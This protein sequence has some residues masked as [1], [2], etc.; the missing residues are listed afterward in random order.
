M[1][2]RFSIGYLALALLVICFARDAVAQGSISGTLTSAGNPTTGYVDLIR[3]SNT[4][5]VFLQTVANPF[6]GEYLLSNIPDGTYYVQTQFATQGSTGL[7]DEVFPNQPCQTP[8]FC[9]F[10]SATVLTIAGGNAITGISF[11]LDPAATI[12]GVVSGPSGPLTSAY[13]ALFNPTRQLLTTRSTAADGTFS[14]GNLPS[15]TYYVTAANAV[16]LVDEIYDNVICPGA[17]C[18]LNIG[19]P[20][21]VTAP[22]TINGI[23]FVLA[24]GSRI[25]GTISDQRGNPL[26]GGV[27]LFYDAAGTAVAGGS[28]DASGLYQSAGG[29]PAGTYTARVFSGA[30]PYFDMIYPE[31]PCSNAQ[32]SPANGLGITV[33]GTN[34]VGNINFR[35]YP[36]PASTN[37]PELVGTWLSM[38]K[39]DGTYTLKVRIK[40]QGRSNAGRF[41]VRLYQSTDKIIAT[42]DRLIKRIRVSSLKARKTKDL[43][44]TFRKRRGSRFVVLSVDHTNTAIETNESNNRRSRRF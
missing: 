41:E 30:A 33:D 10:A 25:S 26:S 27:V 16:G 23:D 31:L 37:A 13:V 20:I 1:K 24:P 39:K 18:A 6:T 15:G 12:N 8:S 11:D 4:S 7:I 17:A 29:L 42:G 40:N 34:P 28:S 5:Q 2:S 3:T 43:E 36:T 44:F 9:P 14:F 38:K 21:P 22:S 35:L 32:C 19:T